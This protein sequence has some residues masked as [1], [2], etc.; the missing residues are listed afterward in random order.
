MTSS[1]PFVSPARSGWGRASA[2]APCTFQLDPC[3]PLLTSAK[4]RPHSS[5]RVPSCQP[6]TR[7]LTPTHEPGAPTCD[8]LQLGPQEAEKVVHHLHHLT[9]R[10]AHV[11]HVAGAAKQGPLGELPACVATAELNALAHL[12]AGGG[13]ATGASGGGWAHALSCEHAREGRGTQ[14]AQACST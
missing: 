6:A 9:Q 4:H 12:R 10:A 13:V 8:S 11:G 14:R 3:H 1:M 2:P 5:R 7:P